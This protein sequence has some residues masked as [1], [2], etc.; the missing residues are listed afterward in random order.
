M[1]VLCVLGI[2]SIKPRPF[3]LTA[4]SETPEAE[5]QIDLRISWGH[6][7]TIGQN[8]SWAHSE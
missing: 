6:I 8:P 7:A 2:M 1:L 3:K 5:I 4:C